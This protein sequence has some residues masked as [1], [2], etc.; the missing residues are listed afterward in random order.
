MKKADLIILSPVIFT[1]FQDETV[2]GM[3]AVV[4]GI[5]EYVGS[6][7]QF[8]QYKGEKTRVIREENGMVVP[9]FHDSHI[10]LYLAALYESGRFI[11]CK[12]FVLI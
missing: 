3:I 5:V 6:N 4:D 11:V 2:S 9:G 12:V 8:E 10:H 1:G 7:D